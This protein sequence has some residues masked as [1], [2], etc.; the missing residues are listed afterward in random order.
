MTLVMRRASRGVGRSV[1]GREHRPAIE[2]RKS[3]STQDADAVLGAEGNMDGRDIA[4]SGPIP[5]SQRPW[6]HSS[7]KATKAT[8]CT[9]GGPGRGCRGDGASGA[10][11]MTGWLGTMDRCATGYVKWR[12][13]Y[14]TFMKE[15]EALRRCNLAFSSAIS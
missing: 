3:F 5:R 14:Y 10:T 12:A 11:C 13:S 6:R 7:W 9:R 8:L 2:P 4:R 15:S 1:G